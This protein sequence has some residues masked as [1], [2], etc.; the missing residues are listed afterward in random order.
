MVTENE[1]ALIQAVID[2]RTPESSGFN[3]MQS[4][5]LPDSIKALRKAVI[6]ERMTEAE[7]ARTFELYKRFR[8]ANLEWNRHNVPHEA[9][10]E[11]G[12]EFDKRIAE[13]LKDV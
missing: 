4:T 8:V 13:E 9:F 3:Q 2:Y 12:P 7:K 5:G 6:L 10:S 11:W 1:R